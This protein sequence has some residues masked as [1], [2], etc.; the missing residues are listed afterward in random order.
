MVISKKS[1]RLVTLFVVFILL[2]ATLFVLFV[3]NKAAAETAEIP[4]TGL[5][6]SSYAP[7]DSVMNATCYIMQSNTL[8]G[9]FTLGSYSSSFFALVRNSSTTPGAQ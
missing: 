7:I 6:Y 2:F 5:D 1:L 4:V 9:V 8:A 3:P